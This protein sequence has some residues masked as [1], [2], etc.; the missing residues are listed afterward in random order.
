MY[1]V[2]I[3]VATQLVRDK[4][5]VLGA[6]LCTLVHALGGNVREVVLLPW[7][8]V[9]LNAGCNALVMGLDDLMGRCWN[10]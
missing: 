1:R 9:R 6:G 5:Q 4:A 10:T 7:L 2:G 3:L 8:Q